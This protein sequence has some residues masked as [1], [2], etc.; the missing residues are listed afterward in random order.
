M[1]IAP[2]ILHRKNLVSPGIFFGI[3]FLVGMIAAVLPAA[4]GQILMSIATSAV[5]GYLGVV[6]M[7]SFMV[8]YLGLTE[9]GKTV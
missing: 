9:K 6:M 7:T 8:F 4:V 5:N 2:F 3:G 1:T